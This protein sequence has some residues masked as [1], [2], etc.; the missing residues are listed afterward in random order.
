MAT[1][2]PPEADAVWEGIDEQLARTAAMLESLSTDQWDRPSLCDGWTVR[3]VAAHLTLQE[4]SFGDLLGFVARHPR[5]WRNLTLNA[6]IRESA[7]IQAAELTT[8][9][10]IRR[11]R[12]GVGSRRHNAFVTPLEKLTDVLVHS[13]DMAVPLGIDL[14]M[15]PDAGA[16]AGTRRW[17]T[18]RTW[19]ASVNR[20]LPLDGI[21]L[22]ATDADWRRGEGSEASGPMGAI[23]L[24]LTGRPAAL[25]RLSGEG[26][27]A[28]RAR[29]DGGHPSPRRSRR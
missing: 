29:L 1:R 18:R 9:E 21:A 28:L 11:I 26:A 22:V 7:V 24:L 8:D 17:D 12:A 2:T 19:L 5:M 16:Q 14:A 23:L 4:Q 13:Q 6:T 15:R 3:H 27:E 20:R 25:D 10:I